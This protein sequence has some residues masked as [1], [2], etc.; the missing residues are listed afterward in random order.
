M[1]SA[2]SGEILFPRHRLEALSDGVFGVVMTLLV[3]ELKLENVP[4]KATDAELLQGLAHNIRP[5]FG[6]ALSF[7]LAGVFWVQQHRQLAMTHRSNAQHIAA[8]LV[9]LFFVTLLP[10]S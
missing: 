5:L 4:P 6:Y 10:F 7:G 9:L 3:L 2:P 8:N 1:S